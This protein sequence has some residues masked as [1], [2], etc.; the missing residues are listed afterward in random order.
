VELLSNQVDTYVVLIYFFF[1][2]AN[3]L[4][5]CSAGNMKEKLWM[6]SKSGR[7]GPWAAGSGGGS[8]A[9]GTGLGGF[10]VPSS[11]SHSAIL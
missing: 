11:P 1:N 8:P 5:G 7:M 6:P 9:H 2:L 4:H 3:I 10:E